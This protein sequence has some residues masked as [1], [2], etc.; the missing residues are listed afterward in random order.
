MKK[1]T[2]W[3]WMWAGALLGALSGFAYWREVG[4]LTGHCPIQS[5]WQSMTL[6]GGIMGFLL[7]DLLHQLIQYLMNSHG[8]TA[9]RNI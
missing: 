1:S 4:C 5:H 2:N 6:W 9:K 8:N 7:G 3:W